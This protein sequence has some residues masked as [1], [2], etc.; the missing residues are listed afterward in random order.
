M[1]TFACILIIWFGLTAGKFVD[2]IILPTP[3]SVAGALVELLTPSGLLIDLVATLLRLLMALVIATAF[4]IPFGLWLGYHE[5]I[6][7]AI[8][9]PLH[10]MR[11]VP[12]TALFPLF[13]ILVGV[14]QGSL[15]AMAAY[16]ALLV[17]LI[18]TISGARLANRRRL[19]QAKI[20]GLGAWATGT[21]VLFWEALP[22]ILAGI[23]IAAGYGLALSIAG[24]MFIGISENGLGRKIYDFQSAYRIPETY[25][26]ILVTGSVGI[27]L[28]QLVTVAER[29]LLRWLPMAS[30]EQ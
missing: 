8:E 19:Q 28:N 29:R 9:G 16:P 17:I 2:P 15:V 30:H 24:E 14:G 4:G 12:P 11:S 20:L 3:L 6:Y 23:R 27:T 26:A 5:R 7:A 18:N 25:A 21:Q 22:H 1:A 10:A 13:L